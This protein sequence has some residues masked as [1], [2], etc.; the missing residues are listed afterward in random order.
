MI[1]NN[2]YQY[3]ELLRKWTLKQTLTEYTASPVYKFPHGPDRSLLVPGQIGLKY[4]TRSGPYRK[5]KLQ[6]C[7]DGLHV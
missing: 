1:S 6:R 2:Y 7:H 4:G 3:T 5:S